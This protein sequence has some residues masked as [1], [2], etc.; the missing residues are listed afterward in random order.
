[1]HICTCTHFQVHYK[2]LLRA[3]CAI[4]LHHFQVSRQEAPSDSA[5]RTKLPVNRSLC[6]KVMQDWREVHLLH[7]N[8]TG[9]R[10]QENLEDKCTHTHR[11]TQQVCG[12]KNKADGGKAES[13]SSLTSWSDSSL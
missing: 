12:R 9:T 4:P 3:P 2:G 7:F 5:M 13:Q 11:C 6:T 1:M 10:T 8:Y